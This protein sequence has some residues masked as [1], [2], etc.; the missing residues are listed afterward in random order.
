MTDCFSEK[1]KEAIA[2]FKENLDGWLANPL[3]RGKYAIISDNQL[4]GLFDHFDTAFIEAEGKYQS[5][6]YII[7]RLISPKDLIGFYSPVI[8]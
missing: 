2:Y 4:V 3:Y 7:Q 1:Q 6:S 5:G 8:A